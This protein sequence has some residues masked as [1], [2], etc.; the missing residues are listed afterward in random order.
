MIRQLRVG[1]D[2]SNNERPAPIHID[3]PSRPSITRNSYTTCTTLCATNKGR[4]T[5]NR[6]GVATPQ[7]ASFSAPLQ[8]LIPIHNPKDTRQLEG[9]VLKNQPYKD[10]KVDTLISTEMIITIRPCWFLSI[11]STDFMRRVMRTYSGESRVIA[12]SRLIRP[13]TQRT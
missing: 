2:G 8:H 10:W 6:S 3:R 7:S 5:F 9:R 1:C 12:W 11:T 4:P 13:Y